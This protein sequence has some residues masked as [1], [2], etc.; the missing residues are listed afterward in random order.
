MADDRDTQQVD[1][2]A[3]DCAVVHGGCW[4]IRRARRSGRKGKVG[5]ADGGGALPR[6]IGERSTYTRWGLGYKPIPPGVGRGTDNEMT[7]LT[8]KMALNPV[9]DSKFLR[10]QPKES[11]LIVDATAPSSSNPIAGIKRS[12]PRS[13]TGSPLLRMLCRA[14]AEPSGASTMKRVEFT[15]LMGLRWGKGGH[16]RRNPRQSTDPMGHDRG[17]ME[18]TN[19]PARLRGW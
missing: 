5:C 17:I 19:H 7:Y 12:R 15:L 11:S 9:V 14:L 4:Y 8:G 10:F 18:G 1:R 3:N 6:W 13:M 16:N 2:R